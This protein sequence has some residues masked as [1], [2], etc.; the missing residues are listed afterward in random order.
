MQHVAAVRWIRLSPTKIMG[1]PSELAG[2]FALLHVAQIW[3]RAKVGLEAIL[4]RG[5]TRRGA[6]KASKWWKTESR[7]RVR[8]NYVT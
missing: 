3:L 2:K 8:V 4:D 7:P 6:G 1:S 5:P